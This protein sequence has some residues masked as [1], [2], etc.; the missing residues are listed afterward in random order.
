MVYAWDFCRVMLFCTNLDSQDAKNN[1]EGTA[2]DDNVP[3][4]L[5]GWHQCLNNQ[6]QSWSSAD[7]SENSTREQMFN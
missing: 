3:D 6:L 1:E 5:E 2:D 4:R 7:H